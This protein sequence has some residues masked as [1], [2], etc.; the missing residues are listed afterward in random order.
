MPER[1]GG[2]VLAFDFGAKRIGVAIGESLL[3]AARALTCI[4]A[5]DRATRF[6]Q[7]AELIATWQPRTLA[8]GLPLNSDGSDSTMTA[9]CRHFARQ[10]ESRFGLPVHL[11]DE[12]YSSVEAEARLA[13]LGHDWRAR[14]QEV[15]AA[16]AAII[17]Q[18]YFDGEIHRRAA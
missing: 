5:I 14:K 12:R 2:T 4:T 13:A 1:S 7:I 17:L 6:A 16:A 15:D 10:L 8:L 3:G 11:V 9:R 18:D